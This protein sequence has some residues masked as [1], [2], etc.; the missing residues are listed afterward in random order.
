MDNN[1]KKML[2]DKQKYVNRHYISPKLP[3]FVLDLKTGCLTSRKY[4][5][6]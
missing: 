1:Y 3:Y 5:L 2:S 4:E 6:G